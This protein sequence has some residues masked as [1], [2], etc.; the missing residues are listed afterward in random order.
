MQ[1]RSRCLV[2]S[3]NEKAN[4]LIRHYKA[5]TSEREQYKAVWDKIGDF[6]N[7]HRQQNQSAGASKTTK[8]YSTA[9]I[10]ALNTLVA[11]LYSLWTSAALPWFRLR[12]REPE[13]NKSDDIKRWLEDVEL[14]MY[15]AFADSS[16]YTMM[17]E[18]YRDLGSYSVS[19][20]YIEEGLYSPLNVE[21]MSPYDFVFAY[22][23]QG[24]VDTVFRYIPLKAR[25]AAQEFPGKV[26][27]DALTQ[28]LDSKD[29]KAY[30]KDFPFL[31]VVC[32]RTDK[33]WWR[34]DNLNFPFGSYYIDMTDSEIVEESGYQE[35]PYAIGQ[36]E[37]PSN[38]KYGSA[39]ASIA[40]PDTQTTNT[41]KRNMLIQEEK[42]L[43]PPLDIPEGYKGRINTNPG[44]LNYRGQGKDRLAKLDIAG[45]LDYSMESLKYDIEQIND[46]FFVDVFRMLASIDRQMTAYEV[47]KREAE[48]MIMFGPV[49]GRLS[50]CLD[51]IIKRSFAIM[52]RG[53]MLPDP[54][55]EVQGQEYDIE[56]ISPLARAQKASQGNSLQEA[57]AFIMPL[58]E[59]KPEI[60]DN[61]DPD[62]I[63]KYVFDL[64]GCPESLTIPEK[65]R[66][67]VRQMR[68]QIA[69]AQAALSAGQQGAQIAKDA[70]QASPGMGSK[71]LGQGA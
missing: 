68:Q 60:L 35:F 34:K 23:N 25:Q 12:M 61:L 70:D 62:E 9:T 51:S 39:P 2:D 5:L 63:F 6:I 18:F 28:C 69:E 17:A 8:I 14:R 30:T 43:N 56:Y 22:N 26:L 21:V 36:W 71:I 55:L 48:R 46:N 29:D 45:R 24:E 4:D 41:R 50:K 37:K 20:V 7:L 32:P 53:G 11:G 64:Y 66:D 16:L 42:T 54:P 19:G 15:A 38:E 10:K 58:S 13:L 67:Q 52:M 44:G 31:H 57:L 1:A 47:S 59:A 49:V 65:Q 33:M 40:L 3:V 27:N